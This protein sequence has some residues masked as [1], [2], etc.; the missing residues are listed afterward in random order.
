MNVLVY[1]NHD[2]PLQLGSVILVMSGISLFA[3]ADGF[4]PTNVVGVVL[5]VGAAVGAATYKACALR[6]FFFFNDTLLQLSYTG[7]VEVESWRSYF[8]PDGTVLNFTESLQHTTSMAY[9]TM[10]ASIGS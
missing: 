8:P 6:L 1:H 7:P 5:S 2:C 10:F 4:Q 3:Y 9:T